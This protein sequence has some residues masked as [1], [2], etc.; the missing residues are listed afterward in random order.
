MKT[1][2]EFS[3]GCKI[4]CQA[5]N[6]TEFTSDNSVKPTEVSPNYSGLYLRG[7]LTY[8]GYTK[9]MNPPT[10]YTKPTRI[11]NNFQYNRSDWVAPF[12]YDPANNIPEINIY[13]GKM[14]NLNIEL[15]N[16]S[17]EE[18]KERET[19]VKRNSIE[20]HIYMYYPAKKQ[21][22]DEKWVSTY[23]AKLKASGVTNLEEQIVSM[24]SRFFDGEGLEDIIKDI[25]DDQ[26]KYY[27]K[28]IK[29]AIRT[30]WAERCIMEGMKAI[31]EDRSINFPKYP[32]PIK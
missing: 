13:G 20:S 29:V 25:P 14:E 2:Q 27:K 8:V 24:A 26:K 6:D 10:L 9:G 19:V 32:L 5:Y 17:V 28:L 15:E 16:V 12:P 11:Y 7:G 21:S 3:F 18:L 30:E 1:L 23:T 31:E 22:Q 4:Y